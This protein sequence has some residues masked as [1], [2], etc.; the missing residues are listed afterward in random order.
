M[1]L[2]TVSLN[3]TLTILTGKKHRQI[4]L[5]RLQKVQIWAFG[6]PVH[7]ISSLYEVLKLK[8]FF[9]K[10]KVVTGKPPFF[11]IGP[12]CTHHSI[13]LLTGQFCME[14]LRFQS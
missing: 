14:M 4:K 12:F 6:L 11:V 9:Q 13:W 3:V 2:L 10:T 1:L 5:Q 8:N 7:Q